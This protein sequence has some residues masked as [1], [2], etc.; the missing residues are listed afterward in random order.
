MADYC[1]KNVK[2]ELVM[3]PLSDNVCDQL[4]RRNLISDPGKHR[5]DNWFATEVEK[6][7]VYKVHICVHC[8][9]PLKA[10]RSDEN[11]LK[12]EKELDSKDDFQQ[13][14]FSLNLP[15]CPES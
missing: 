2:Y 11:I 8:D 15:H 3:S 9:L 5:Q 14:H 13:D 1:N 4:K 12:L 10:F 7:Q 6:Q